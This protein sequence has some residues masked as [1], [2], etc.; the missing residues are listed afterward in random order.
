MASDE[1]YAAFLDKANQDTGAPAS[2]K[3][4]SFTTKAVDSAVPQVLQQIEEYYVSDADE[5]FEPV[6]LKWDGDAMPSEGGFAK[7]IGHDSDASS[8]SQKDFDPKNQYAKVID[9]VKQAGSQDVS[10]FRVQHGSTRAEYYV[11]SLDKKG[12]KI[13]GLKAVAVES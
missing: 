7:L 10:I 11:V 4:K 5:P 6:S 3:S 9:A 2:A 13:V 8:I 12:G 1:D